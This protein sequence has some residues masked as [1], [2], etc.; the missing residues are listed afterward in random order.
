VTKNPFVGNFE[1]REDENE[2]LVNHEFNQPSAN[3]SEIYVKNHSHDDQ[4][5]QGLGTDSGHLLK[6][7]KIEDGQNFI[8]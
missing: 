7:F 1:N 3:I 8:Q 4:F 2:L 5:G 6:P